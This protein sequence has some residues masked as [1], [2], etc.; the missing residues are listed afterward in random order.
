MSA[1]GYA[2]R[3]LENL[4]GNWQLILIAAAESL[5]I[6][7]FVIFPIGVWGYRKWQVAEDAEA[8]AESVLRIYLDVFENPVILIGIFVLVLVI[9]TIALV[10]HS[11]V[12]AGIVRIYLAGEREMGDRAR[13]DYDPRPSTFDLGVWWA[14]AKS[15]W[16]DIFLIYNL[17]WGISGLLILLPLLPLL[18]LAFT[19]NDEQRLLITLTAGGCAWALLTLVIVFLSRAWANLAIARSVMDDLGV[20]AAARSSIDIIT[21]Q[22]VTTLTLI[23]LMVLISLGAGAGGSVVSYSTEAIPA[24]VAISGLLALVSGLINVFI[25]AA[26]ALWMVASFV[27]MAFDLSTHEPVDHGKAFA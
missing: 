25:S 15:N 3:G 8:F 21:R 4:I 1:L 18:F 22:P 26:A 2:R 7:L 5:L 14:G 12:M 19:A 16:F 20:M 27:A 10:I 6:F 23:F 11:M 17:V 9:G 24:V 13:I